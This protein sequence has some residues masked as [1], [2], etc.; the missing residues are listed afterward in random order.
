M[1]AT[2]VRRAVIAVAVV[3]LAAFPLISGNLYVQDL[4]IMTFLLGIGATGWNIM[5]GYAA[6][7]P[8][9][10]ASSSGSARTRPASWPSGRTSRRS[11]A[12]WPAAWSA[13]WP[14]PP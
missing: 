5:G 8:S 13:R 12:A 6:T 3:I 14:P 11:P 9:A 1:S 7:S 10:T 2:A 4:L